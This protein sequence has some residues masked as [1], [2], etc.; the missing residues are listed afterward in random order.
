[1]EEVGKLTQKRIN[2]IH[3][4]Q[5]QQE[6]AWGQIDAVLKTQDDAKMLE[7]RLFGNRIRDRKISIQCLL[8]VAFL[9]VHILYA[10]KMCLCHLCLLRPVEKSF[11]YYTIFY[12]NQ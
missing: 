1:M 12:K 8:M 3:G 5:N 10:Y 7:V 11:C 6:T 2:L 9:L 4:I